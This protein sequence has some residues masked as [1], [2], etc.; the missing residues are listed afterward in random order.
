MNKH[1]HKQE[2][3]IDREVP[4]HQSLIQTMA[5]WARGGLTAG[6]PP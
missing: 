3:F 4:E 5:K 2:D 6:K 1:T